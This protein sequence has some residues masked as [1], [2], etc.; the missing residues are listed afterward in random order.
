VAGTP[1]RTYLQGNWT[2]GAYDQNP[3][4]RAAWG[5]FGSAPKNFIYQRENY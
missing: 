4:N 3:S 2:G 5:L 1:A